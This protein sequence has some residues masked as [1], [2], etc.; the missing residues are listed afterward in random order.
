MSDDHCS[1]SGALEVAATTITL[2]RSP[3]DND[4]IV[5]EL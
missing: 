5:L 4:I 2:L 1:K 3:L